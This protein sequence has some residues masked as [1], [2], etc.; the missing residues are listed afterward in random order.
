VPPAKIVVLVGEMVTLTG[1]GAGIVTAA[2]ALLVASCALV[3]FTVKEPAA[4][5]AVK[6]PVE[7]TVPPVALQVMAVFD[8]P[9]TVAVNCF[10]APIWTVALAGAIDTLTPI[11]TDA[12]A[13]LVVS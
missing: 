2:V 1:C 4:D 13:L 11:V 7:D 9:V 6:S 10:V 12:D 8:A 5:P 3:A